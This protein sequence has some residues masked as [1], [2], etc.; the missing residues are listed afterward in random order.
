MA[1]QIIALQGEIWNMHFDPI[2]GHEQGGF[3][4]ALV[5]SQGAFN[6]FEWDRSNG[7]SRFRG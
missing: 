6:I 1:R 5:V 4:P 2:I 3:R 7:W